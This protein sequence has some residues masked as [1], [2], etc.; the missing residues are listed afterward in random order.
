MSFKRCVLQLLVQIE[1]KID[2][3]S[4]Q[5]EDFKKA[6]DAAFKD[7]SDS[8]DNI[9]K[10]E[11]GLAKQIADFIAAQGS[12]SPPDLATL[13]TIAQNAVAMAD[14]TKSIADNVPDS[15]PSV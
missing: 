1:G 9:V 12:L 6:V 14:R 7:I 13:T 3:M 2:Q 10:D 4:Q 11:E 8:L 5:V 15:A